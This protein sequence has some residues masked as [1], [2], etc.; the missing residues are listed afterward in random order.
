MLIPLLLA[1]SPAHSSSRYKLL[2]FD[3]Y[4]FSTCLFLPVKCDLK[5]RDIMTA[6][7]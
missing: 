6:S 1:K 3:D 7:A 5:S 2:L 4:Y